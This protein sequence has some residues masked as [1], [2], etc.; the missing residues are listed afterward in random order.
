MKW[1]LRG[2]FSLEQISAGPGSDAPPRHWL[3]RITSESRKAVLELLVTAPNG[4]SRRGRVPRSGWRVPH[5]P[6][7]P[8]TL[9]RGTGRDG[10]RSRWTR[11][12]PDPG[13]GSENGPVGMRFE[14]IGHA[15]V[16]LVNLPSQGL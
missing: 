15:G 11:H 9:G 16:E 7:R 8:A 3:A 13:K 14:L 6:G 12:D 5:W 2:P 10:L 1:R 4:R